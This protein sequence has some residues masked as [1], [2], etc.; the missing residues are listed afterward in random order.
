MFCCHSLLDIYDFA[1]N[2]SR[3]GTV[4]QCCIQEQLLVPVPVAVTVPLKHMLT[5]HYSLLL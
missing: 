1:I 3:P 5:E 4:K 2:F